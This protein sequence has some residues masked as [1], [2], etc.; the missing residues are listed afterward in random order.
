MTSLT[1]SLLAADIAK[2]PSSLLRLTASLALLSRDTIDACNV[3]SYDCH[4]PA[5]VI[6]MVK[7]GFKIRI[8]VTDKL[9]WSKGYKEGRRDSP[10]SIPKPIC[11]ITWLECRFRW[12]TQLWL[13]GFGRGNKAG[14]AS[15]TSLRL[16]SVQRHPHRSEVG[17]RQTGSF[18][19]GA[20][21][22]AP[23]RPHLNGLRNFA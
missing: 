12:W 22:F 21:G 7:H 18:Q 23:T 15:R 13:F 1:D 17:T 11:Q 14:T 10:R 9:D 5:A 20:N 4:L 8:V 19:Q 16:R 2:S 6:E 3:S